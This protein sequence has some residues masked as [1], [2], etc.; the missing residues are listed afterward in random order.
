[1][2]VTTN[3]DAVTSNDLDLGACGGI[4]SSATVYRTTADE[5]VNLHEG[6]ITLSAKGQLIDRLPARSITTYVIDGV[7]PLSIP[8]SSSIGGTHQIFSQ[9]T[10]L[11]LNITRNSTQCGDGI[12]PYPR[13]ALSNMEFNFVDQGAGFYSIQTVNG[14]KSLCLN[15]ADSSAA[16]RWETSWRTGKFNSVELHRGSV[17]RQ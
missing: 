17:A 12:I 7:S 16:R 13:T 3:W 1:V 5:G 15:V 11:C 6:S 8:A 10:K 14:A 4:P 2:L 9:G